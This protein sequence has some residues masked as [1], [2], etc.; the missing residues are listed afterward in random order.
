MSSNS[1]T[2][3]DLRIIPS[4]YPLPHEEHD[5]QRSLPLMQI[6]K[7]TSV[8]TNPPIL[9][10]TQD[11]QYIILDGANRCHS[12][13]TLQFPYILVQ[14]V[15]YGQNVSLGNWNH[16]LSDWD[17]NSFLR[18][19]KTLESVYVVDELLD[20][21]LGWIHTKEGKA[22]TI[23]AQQHMATIAERNQVLRE[24]VRLY[25][26]NSTLSRTPNNK[27]EDVWQTFPSAFAF[28]TFENYHPHDIVDAAINQAFLPPGISRHVVQGR[29]LQLNY[30]MDILRRD[31]ESADEKN[32]QLQ[33]WIVDRFKNRSVR[34]YAESTY[35][36]NE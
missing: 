12:F 27:P 32:R 13:Q 4:S 5:S 26:Q 23:L 29:V 34:F 11:N 30:P 24:V 9:T 7:T 35:H 15:H 28:I 1:I 6:L 17:M 36:F 19:L 20:E 25:Q 22:Y 3:P 31:D 21:G 16:A 18:E 33:S 2:I 10:V 14:V 8:F